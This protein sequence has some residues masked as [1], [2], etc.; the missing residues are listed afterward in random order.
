MSLEQINEALAWWDNDPAPILMG[1]KEQVLVEA[2]RA[3]VAEW[4][5]CPN[6]CE[7]LNEGRFYWPNPDE[8]WTTLPCDCVDGMVPSPEL[9]E[10]V[11][12]AMRSTVQG[13]EFAT[14]TAAAKTALL[15]SRQGDTE[16]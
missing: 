7:L 2:A 16:Q 12:A 14:F 9:V 4:A 8:P 5:T 6:E 11:A 1:S 3:Y 13:P 15:A 10:R